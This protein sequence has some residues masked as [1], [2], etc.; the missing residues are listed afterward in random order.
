M[1]NKSLKMFY[2]W[3]FYSTA[4]YLR[5]I[6]AKV[7]AFGINMN[8]S[9]T[10]SLHCKITTWKQCMFTSLCICNALQ[11]HFSCSFSYIP[12]GFVDSCRHALIPA[13]NCMWNSTHPT[14]QNPPFSW[15]K[16]ALLWLLWKDDGLKKR[17]LKA[18][19]N[20][21]A[22]HRGWVEDSLCFI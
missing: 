2:V 20:P 21:T 1:E 10:F 12:F 19:I 22:L 11:V 9:Q 17:A 16:D 18:N 6:P 15:G 4:A 8:W 3:A 14:N 5:I 7:L 13:I